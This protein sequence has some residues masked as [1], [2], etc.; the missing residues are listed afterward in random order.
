[1]T[2]AQLYS[3][4]QGRMNALHD[5]AH[6]RASLR[7]V[8]EQLPAGRLVLL[9]TSEQGAGL[10]AAAAASRPEPTFWRRVDAMLPVDL[11]SNVPI[12]IVEPIEGDTAWRQM[13]KHRWP[14]AIV[15]VTD[16]AGEAL[17]A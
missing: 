5:G 14:T 1:M 4:R 7:R 11:P 8:L 6:L 17:A 13:I 10:A 12:V 9:S 2:L 15:I 3:E 16:E